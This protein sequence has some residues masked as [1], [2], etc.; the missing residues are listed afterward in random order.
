[1]NPSEST[2]PRAAAIAAGLALALAACGGSGGDDDPGTTPPPTGAPLVVT[3][4][5]LAPGAIWQLDRPIELE[6]SRAIDPGTLTQASV[7]VREAGPGGAFVAGTLLVAADPITGAPDPARAVFQPACPTE[8]SGAGG[9]LAPGGID[10]TLTV[11]GADVP[12]GVPIR[13]A[14]GAPL[15]ATLE[16][17]FRTPTPPMQLLFDRKPGPPALVAR[18]DAGVLD[19][20]ENTTRIEVG[21]FAPTTVSLRR[22]P[23][24]GLTVD[25]GSA[26]LFPT[27]LPINHWIEPEHRLVVVLELDDTV[28]AAPSNLARVDLRFQDAGGS[29]RPLPT[30][31]WL[32]SNCAQRGSSRATL[33]A[34]PLGMIPPGRP[35]AV[36]I[37]EGFADRVGD[38][39]LI[40]ETF[41]LGVQGTTAATPAGAR[42]DAV[43]EPFDLG[44]G[45]PFSMEDTTSDLGAPRATWGPRGLFPTETP[46][47]VS[48]ARSRWYALGRGG[49]SPG[50]PDVPPIFS[51]Y[52]TDANG[53]VLR[54]GNRVALGPVALGPMAASVLG[55]AEVALPAAFLA[56]PTGAI[57]DLPAL[58]RFDRAL[59]TPDPPGWGAVEPVILAATVEGN[60]ARLGVESGC[61]IPGVAVD[62]APLNLPLL[63]GPSAMPS[64]GIVRQSFQI[65]TWVWRDAYDPDHRVTITWDAARAGGDGRPDPATALSRSSGW[66]GDP[67]TL[68]GGD[69]DFVR[70]EVE[71]D[72]DVSGNGYD[73]IERGPV[74]DFIKL[75]F[76]VR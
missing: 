41:A 31:T 24:G 70:F 6:F 72:L 75:P 47:G 29:W 15:E 13:A 42:V 55:W 53:D 37:D 32:A 9:G 26:S 39:T 66:T 68:S 69:W 28:G 49:F 63:Y 14:D 12:G 4:P 7:Y 59:F 35:L 43:L 65:F 1:M 36:H 73:P 54:N 19:A 25:P 51:W 48:R 76:D 52:G 38:A 58:L 27:G 11:Q 46:D 60:E 8:P 67:T 3:T 44:G 18:G 10:Y 64:V 74:L 2:R 34:M 22:A 61:T 45:G 16:E 57:S 17:T 71:F 21:G 33:R 20:P 5:G 40:P 50:Q 62:C 23:G 56:D 30:R